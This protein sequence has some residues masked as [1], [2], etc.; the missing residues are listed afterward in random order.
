MK[1]TVIGITDA[2]K[3]FFTPEVMEIIRA[4]T[5]FSGGKRHHEIMAPLLPEKALWIDITAPLDAVFEQYG[6]L[7]A[8]VIVFASGDPLFFGF[9]NTIRRLLPKAEIELFPS[10][11][12]LQMLAHRLEKSECSPTATTP[13]QPSHNGCSTMGTIITRCTWAFIWAIP[14][15]NKW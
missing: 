2:P 9:A 15:V 1:F 4:G 10:F 3:P 13:R 12:S 7:D 5:V 11:N 14:N 6:Q 8:D